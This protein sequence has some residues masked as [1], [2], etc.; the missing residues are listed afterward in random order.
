MKILVVCPNA[1]EAAYI[2][3]QTPNK[4]IRVVSPGH[5][6]SD[7]YD[8]IFVTDQYRREQNFATEETRERNKRW[9]EESVLTRL[10]GPDGRI[11]Y[12]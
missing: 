2:R 6:T 11:I 7:R 5:H 1:S 10:S 9:F 8:V 12:L 4:K 3:R